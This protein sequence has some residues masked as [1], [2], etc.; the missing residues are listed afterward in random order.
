VLI[1]QYG[2]AAQAFTPTSHGGRKDRS[3]CAR[4]GD[5]AQMPPRL[6]GRIG[7][8]HCKLRLS[9]MTDGIDTKLST[10]IDTSADV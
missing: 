8:K 3:L 10:V 6:R 2:D 1:N 7:E 5:F 9:Y 4:N